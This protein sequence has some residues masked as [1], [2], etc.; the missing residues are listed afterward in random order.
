MN[1]WENR[2]VQTQSNGIGRFKLHFMNQLGG[3]EPGH[4]M[5]G[6][7]WNR[8]DGLSRHLEE[9]Q[10]EITI[11]QDENNGVIIPLEK[12]LVRSSR[13]GTIS[14]PPTEVLLSINNI[15]AMKRFAGDNLLYDGAFQNNKR[16]I[17][18]IV[19]RC[20]NPV[21][22]TYTSPKVYLK[23]TLILG[24]ESY[25]GLTQPYWKGANTNGGGYDA[26][27]IYH[28]FVIPADDVQET[29]IVKLTQIAPIAAYLS[30]VVYYNWKSSDWPSD[31]KP[32]PR[33]IKYTTD[34]I[35]FTVSTKSKIGHRMIVNPFQFGNPTIKSVKEGNIIYS[36]YIP[37]NGIISRPT[38]FS[39]DLPSEFKNDD[40]YRTSSV[41]NTTNEASIYRISVEASLLDYAD[42]GLGCADTYL[43]SPGK[44]L[45]D[46]SYIPELNQTDFMYGYFLMKLPI[47]YNVT[48]ENTYNS[49][50]C[51]YMSISSCFGWINIIT[52][53]SA[54]NTYSST[55]KSDGCLTAS[56]TYTSTG[57]GCANSPFSVNTQM[58]L[59]N[60]SAL[61]FDDQNNAYMFALYAPLQEVHDDYYIPNTTNLLGAY[62]CINSTTGPRS[63]RYQ[64]SSNLSNVNAFLL[65]APNSLWT[66]RYRNPSSTWQGSPSN[67]G[68]NITDFSLASK[69][70]LGA[71]FPILQPVQANSIDDLVSKLKWNKS[72]SKIE[73]E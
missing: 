39:D 45:P 32:T 50:D 68:C 53:E 58:Y 25:N 9:K 57:G 22:N 47:T 31:V 35:V 65:P 27:A 41:L 56:P 71:F 40:I 63:N 14:E 30:I 19:Y 4:S 72:T 69:D 2:E 54:F 16:Q 66:I 12:R 44:Y 13:V 10:L 34:D 61:L 3:V 46:V 36:S 70:E 43:M 49:Y 33:V 29:H 15:P 64:T 21:L 48:T 59:D 62:S 37:G 51:V 1:N 24:Y 17:T 55:L 73:M 11:K 26:Q 42:S 5:F 20:Y 52:P 7:R 60:R 18:N 38:L 67:V 8:G 28:Q 6:G 23:D